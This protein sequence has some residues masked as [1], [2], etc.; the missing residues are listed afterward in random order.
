MQNW[1]LDIMITFTFVSV[2]LLYD[3]YLIV[4]ELSLCLMDFAP[5]G[6]GGGAGASGTSTLPQ[7]GSCS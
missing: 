5:E 2:K 7:T 4:I 1:L 6:V 3:F